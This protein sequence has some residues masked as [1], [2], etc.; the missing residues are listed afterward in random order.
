M[1][2]LLLVFQVIDTILQNSSFPTCHVSKW[3]VATSAQSLNK[4]VEGTKGQL[5]ALTN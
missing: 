5:K 3:Q 1:M 4:L 2:L